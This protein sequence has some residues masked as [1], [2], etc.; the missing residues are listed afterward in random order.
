MRSSAV[1][2]LA[3]LGMVLSAGCTSRFL[4]A[5]DR[6]ETCHVVVE[7]K[8]GRPAFVANSLSSGA[9]TLSG[10]GRGAL[11]GLQAGGGLGVIVTLPLGTLIGAG[12]GTACAVADAQ[13]PDAEADFERLLLQADAGL[14]KRDLDAFFKA[15][16]AGCAAPLAPTPDAVLQIERI[17]SGM[18]CLIG[19]QEFWVSVEWR[20][21]SRKTG[22]V[23][24]L[25]TSRRE[26]T[27]TREVGDWFAHP[28][29]GRAEIESLLGA[30]GGDIAAQFI[31]AE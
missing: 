1:V 12:Y 18:A 20:T 10:A 16:R 24:N 30:I 11:M 8:F 2:A 4:S 9:G 23:L 5:E 21:V 26:H 6:R 17:Q 3:A 13:H 28:E 7:E 22:K 14:L 15:P 27:S 25:T 19:R 29:E 31:P